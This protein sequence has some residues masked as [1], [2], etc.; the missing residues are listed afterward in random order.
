MCVP[1]SM[2]PIRAI[3]VFIVAAL[4]FSLL[5][6][7]FSYIVVISFL[8]PQYNLYLHPISSVF[9]LTLVSLVHLVSPFLFFYS[10]S[11]SNCIC[12]FPVND[13][14]SLGQYGAHNYQQLAVVVSMD[15]IKI[16]TQHLAYTSPMPNLI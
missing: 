9:R 7:S 15:K 2:N 6:A 11:S 1:E 4:S 12:A 5:H 3:Y 16:P 10:S 14:K 8:P 13:A